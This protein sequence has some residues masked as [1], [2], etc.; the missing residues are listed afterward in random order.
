MEFFIYRDNKQQGPYTPE[1]LAGMGITS[2]TL[3][4]SEGMEQWTPAW[5]VTEL[6][7]VLAGKVQAR[8]VPPPVPPQAGQQEESGQPQGNRQH[9]NTM[10][11]SQPTGATDIP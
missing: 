9:R 10:P 6:K 3:V 4:W 11:H 7:D 5:Q 8:P 1:Q 2:E